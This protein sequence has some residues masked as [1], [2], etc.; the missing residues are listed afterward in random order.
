MKHDPTCQ[1]CRVSRLHGLDD[2]HTA[3]MH[4]IFYR[5][6]TVSARTAREFAQ[7]QNA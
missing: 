6:G 4:E 3:L 5:T 1:T 2:R 7:A